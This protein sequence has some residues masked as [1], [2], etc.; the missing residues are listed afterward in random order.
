MIVISVEGQ[1]FSQNQVELKIVVLRGNG[2]KLN[3]IRRPIGVK[4]RRPP[5]VRSERI[6]Q[7]F[8]DLEEKERDPKMIPFS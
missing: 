7:N 5:P 6:R 4:Y 3:L 2:I 8:L 1:T